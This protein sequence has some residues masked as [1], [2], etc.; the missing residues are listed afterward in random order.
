M[1]TAEILMM[2]RWKQASK[3]A[4]LQTNRRWCQTM[5]ERLPASFCSPP[6][7]L[8][9]A[10]QASQVPLTRLTHLV[11]AKTRSEGSQSQGTKRK[12]PELNF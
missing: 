7:K 9:G 8:K 2:A 3:Q 10:Q 6:T 11:N 4:S 1:V 12:T 5:N